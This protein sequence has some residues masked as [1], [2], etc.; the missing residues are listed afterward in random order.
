MLQEYFITMLLDVKN[1]STIKLKEILENYLLELLFKVLISL[2][3]TILKISKIL[4]VFNNLFL[5][6]L[7]KVKRI[8]KGQLS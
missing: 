4:M 8:I 7:L 5:F 6:V 3:L 1:G 2:S